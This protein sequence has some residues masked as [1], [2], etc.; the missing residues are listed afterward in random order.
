MWVF[1][2]TGFVSA[3][4]DYQDSSKLVVRSRDKKS[5]RPF[6]EATN[7]EII[8]LKNRDYEY[9]VIIKKTDF[10]KCLVDAAMT[11]DY[12]NFK[13]RIWDTRGDVF[14]DALSKVWGNMLDVSDKYPPKKSKNFEETDDFDDGMEEIRNRIEEILGD[15]LPIEQDVLRMRFGIGDQDLK[16][17]KE[18][19]EKL[20][21]SQDEVLDIERQAISRAY[22]SSII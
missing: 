5:L 12:N 9:R 22:G 8:E 7:A 4:V 20:H 1:T 19:G 10:V 21:I 14:H 15:L 11:I 18:V 13:N 3:V 2:E 17:L 16:T 6:V